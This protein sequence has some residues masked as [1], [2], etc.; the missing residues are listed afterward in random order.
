MAVKK[1]GRRQERFIFKPVGHIKSRYNHYRDIPRPHGSTGWTDDT[2][3]VILYPEHAKKLEGLDGYSHL[4]IIYWIH[5]ASEWRMPKDHGKPPKVRLFATRMPVRPNP[6][7]LSVVQLID[8]SPKTGRIKVKGLDALNGSPL[9]DI[10]PYIPSFDSI[11]GATLPDWLKKHL[12][13]HHH[14]HHIK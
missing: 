9:L 5:K 14:H 1:I 8:F 13:K 12:K 3:W 7:G 11:S 4:I 6:V 10:K 2:S